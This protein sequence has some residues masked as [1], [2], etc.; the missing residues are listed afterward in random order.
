MATVI[1][2]P[3]AMSIV[4]SLSGVVVRRV[5]NLDSITYAAWRGGV[6]YVVFTDKINGGLSV[7]GPAVA[8]V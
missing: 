2:K 3:A 6:C 1:F 5:G 8:E 7:S 4:V